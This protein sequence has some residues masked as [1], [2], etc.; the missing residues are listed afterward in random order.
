MGVDIP[1]LEIY[2]MSESTGAHSINILGGGRWRVGSAGQAVKGA[3][4]KI[5]CPDENG[6]GEVGGEVWIDGERYG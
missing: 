3:E 1:I 5:S 2:G 6:D 4:M